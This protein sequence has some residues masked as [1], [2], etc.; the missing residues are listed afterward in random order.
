MADQEAFGRRSTDVQIAELAAAVRELVEDTRDFKT[1]LQDS[2]E[3]RI[4]NLEDWRVALTATELERERNKR[5]EDSNVITK[6]QF[7]MGLAGLMLAMIGSAS[8]LAVLVL[9]HLS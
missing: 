1:L 3:P 8:G 2:V 7:W 9:S 4:K 6:R 5:L